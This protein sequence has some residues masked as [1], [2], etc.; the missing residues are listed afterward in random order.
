M[1]K[2]GFRVGMLGVKDGMGSSEESELG[3]ERENIGINLGA[4]PEMRLIFFIWFFLKYLFR[5][6]R[7][8]SPL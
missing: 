7:C 2:C 8:L 5:T 1:S 4:H 6:L 3:K